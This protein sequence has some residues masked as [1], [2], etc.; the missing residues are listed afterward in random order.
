MNVFELLGVISVD[1]R[2]ANRELDSIERKAGRTGNQ[3][4]S[5]FGRVGKVVGGAFLA[6]GAAAGATLAGIATAGIRSAAA[7]EQ[8]R[9]AFTV[10]T[11]SAERA[12]TVLNRIEQMA[13]RTPFEFPE[14]AEAGQRLLA[15]GLAAEEVP[16]ALQA[17]GDIAAGIGAPIGDIAY[18][19]G[20]ARTQG[21]LFMQ[22][23]NQLTNRG[24][25][26]IAE[27]ARQ[28]GVTEAEVKELVSSGQVEFR[29]LE[30]A[31]IS[32]TGEGGQF[33]GMMD[34]QSQ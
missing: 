8:T 10:L 2:D 7:M 14:L 23:I 15:F 22:D 28:F 13:Q 9:T 6:A 19:Y 25:P 16:E 33:F 26:I 21:R 30:A 17:I 29:H 12:E 32:L 27:L 18:L 34:E 5:I 11:G 3:L 31:F 24:I 1:T 20:T 4:T